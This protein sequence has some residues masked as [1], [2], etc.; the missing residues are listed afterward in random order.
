MR[1]NLSIRIWVF[2]IVVSIIIA[3]QAIYSARNIESFQQAYLSTLQDKFAK[4]GGYFKDEVEYVLN[5]KIPLEKLIKIEDTLQE[6]LE[7]SPELEFIEITDM[8]GFVLFFADHRSIG[9][10]EPGTRKSNT[11]DDR[12]TDRLHSL[13]LDTKAT[14][15]VLP[16]FYKRQHEQVGYINMRISPDLIVERSR[17]ILLDMVTVILTSLLITFEF[18]SFFVIYSIS[19]PLRSVEKA[20]KGAVFNGTTVA[21]EA[22]RNMGELEYICIRFNAFMRKF[23]V[24]FGPFIDL[25]HNVKQNA[26]RL[27]DMADRLKAD[28]HSRLLIGQEHLHIGVVKLLKK[29]EGTT[30]KFIESLNTFRGKIGSEAFDPLPRDRR[31]HARA[32]THHRLPYVFIRPLIFLFVMSDGFCAS[33]LPMFADTLYVPFW[34][35]SREVILGMPISMFMLFMALSMP[36]SG[37]LSDR[38]G[39]YPLLVSGILLNSM[40]LLLTAISITF[41]QLIVFRSITAIGFGMVYMSSQRFVIDRT[42]TYNRNMGMA[43]F[44]A[45]FFSGDICGT[46]IGGMLADRI[47][48]RN[49]FVVSCIISMLALLVCILIL[50]GGKPVN[51]TTQKNG[52]GTFPLR[53]LFA[54]LKDI[55]F[56]SIVF[57]QAIPAKLILIGFLFYFV[58][59]YLRSIGTLQSDIGRI[60][61]CYGVSL[62]FLGPFFSRFFD[63]KGFREIYIATGGMISGAAMLLFYFQSGFYPLLLIIVMLGIAHTFSVS[64]QASVISETRIVKKLGS[65]TG[66]GI[67]RFWERVGN[68]IGPLIMGTLITRVGYEQAVVILGWGSLITTMLYIM[69]IGFRRRNKRV[70]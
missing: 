58:P 62:I 60:I 49:V 23:V 40:G 20:I 59:L 56:F 26:G 34:G 19:D 50:R 53:N 39:W 5:L 18:L 33:F 9:R 57:L 2:L 52:K 65:G 21:P 45:A 24:A 15:T 37:S 11:L 10:V 46:V 17:E 35:I 22:A 67:F 68:V 64:S 54:A 8:H 63:K 14:D 55:E 51:A 47:G 4:L 36:F 41:W 3:G 1:L 48:Y 61:M 31:S 13:G 6:I 43:S 16:V 30:L 7:A 44:L 12:M 69:V 28:I 38:V 29:F 42:T 70:L 32:A 27:L 25:Q 66:M